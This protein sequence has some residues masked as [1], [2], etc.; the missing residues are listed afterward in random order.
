LRALSYH[1][2]Y[3]QLKGWSTQQQNEFTKKNQGAYT[4]CVAV[5]YARS[6]AHHSNSFGAMAMV[7]GLIPF[8]GLALGFSTAAGAALWASDLEK[9]KSLQSMGDA[10]QKQVAGSTSGRREL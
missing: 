2:R 4:G 8:A 7:L 6:V 10:D 3:F 5:Q 9:H 1:S